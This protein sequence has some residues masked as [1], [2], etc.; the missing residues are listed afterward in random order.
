MKLSEKRKRKRRVL[1]ELQRDRRFTLV[2]R[3]ETLAQVSAPKKG[4]AQL[5]PL[6]FWR[7]LE[8]SELRVFQIEGFAFCVFCLALEC[9][10]NFVWE[11]YVGSRE[12]EK[13]QRVSNVLLLLRS[14]IVCFFFFFVFLNFWCNLFI[15]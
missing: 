14:N 8:C 15:P 5:Q 7:I 6:R 12:D 2:N 4:E 9:L 1:I 10:S 11:C 13:E 3:I